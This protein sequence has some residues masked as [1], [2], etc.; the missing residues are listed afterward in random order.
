MLAGAADVADLGDDRSPQLP[1][2]AK[3][4]LLRRR[5]FV[6]EAMAEDAGKRITQADAFLRQNSWDRTWARIRSLLDEAV[7]DTRGRSTPVE[8]ATAV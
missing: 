3:V 4:P 2:D 5:R 6:L 1:L 7:G 8:D